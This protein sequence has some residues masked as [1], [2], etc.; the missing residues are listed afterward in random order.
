[1]DNAS[2][3]TD[4]I[5]YCTDMLIKTEGVYE[6]HYTLATA[7]V[8]KAICNP[9]WVDESQCLDLLIPALSE[10]RHALNITFAPGIVRDTL[11]DLELIRAAGIEGLE[12]VFAL[13]EQALNRDTPLAEDDP[14]L[15]TV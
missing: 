11:R 8:G 12:P 15:I 5:T 9:R 1:M 2:A 6:P 3:F 13:L 4:A 10:Y 14:D 7:L